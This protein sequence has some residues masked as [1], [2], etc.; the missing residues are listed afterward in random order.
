MKIYG[1]ANSGNCY[2]LK[3]LCA[4]LSIEHEWITVDIL[5]GETGSEQFLAMNPNGQIPVCITDDGEVL[6][7]SNA[8]LYYLGQGSLYWP[9][10][11]LA[12]TRV[13]EWQFFEQYSHEPG[14]AVARFIRLYQGMP[15]ARQDEYQACLRTG[16]RALNVMEERL[17]LQDYLAT[18]S[19]SLADISLYAYTHVAHEG[20]FD[21]STFPAIRAWISR[22]QGLD[23]YVSMNNQYK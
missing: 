19:V 17:Q 14:V 2:K 10:D 18:D 23:D 7:Q 11:L 16:Y 5:R 3:L 20:G 6:T 21:L 15:A 8:I 12:Q 13:L 4:L 1:D 9:A 22:I